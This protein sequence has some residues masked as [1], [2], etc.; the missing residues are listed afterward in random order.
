MKK[1]T[2]VATQE[3]DWKYEYDIAM[4][5][6]NEVRQKSHARKATI[7]TLVEALKEILRFESALYIGAEALQSPCNFL[8][9]VESAKQLL[10]N[11]QK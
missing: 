7:D 8:K 6:L 5:T 2:I 4:K 11:L 10:N 1:E 9:A 3:I